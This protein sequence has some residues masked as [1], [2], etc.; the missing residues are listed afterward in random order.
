MLSDVSVCSANLLGWCQDRGRPFH[1]RLPRRM[2][3]LCQ[4]RRAPQG[5]RGFAQSLQGGC[6]LWVF[7]SALHSHLSF[8]IP[9]GGVR[10]R[11]PPAPF[12]SFHRTGLMVTGHFGCPPAVRNVPGT[13]CSVSFSPHRTTLNWI[14]LN[15]FR[16][17]RTEMLSDFSKVTQLRSEEA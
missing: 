7:L 15:S 4:F 14:L 16:R 10:N 2:R 5:G 17:S 6:L 3:G 13:Q 9:G 1:G 12:L 8:H 11:N